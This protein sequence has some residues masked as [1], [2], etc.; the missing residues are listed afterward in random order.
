[1]NRIILA[2]IFTSVFAFCTEEVNYRGGA[3]HDGIFG[4]VREVPANFEYKKTYTYQLWTRDFLPMSSTPFVYGYRIF[5][6]YGKGILAFDMRDFHF[7]KFALE[8]KGPFVASPI[9]YKGI[10]F[11]G[12][13]KK[14]LFYALD[15]SGNSIK[16]LW[17]SELSGPVVSAA[18]GADDRVLV[19]TVYGELFCLNLKGEIMWKRR[20]LPKNVE[21]SPKLTYCTPVVRDGIIYLNNGRGIT[22][23][24]VADGSVNCNLR[25]QDLPEAEFYSTPCLSGKYLFFTQQTAVYRIDLE[26]KTVVKYETGF[27]GRGSPACDDRNVYVTM[28]QNHFCI[29][30]ETM[31]SLWIYER[32]YYKGRSTPLILKDSVV[33]TD[34][35]NCIYLI[36]KKT[37]KCLSEDPMRRFGEPVEQQGG[38]IYYDNKIFWGPWNDCSMRI[39]WKGIA[40]KGWH[41]W[42][43]SDPGIEFDDGKDWKTNILRDDPDFYED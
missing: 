23:W 43:D 40:Y 35:H 24:K 42:K 36:D 39:Y 37:G 5:F 28:G 22:G 26:Q 3:G 21:H 10:L 27:E 41:F 4:T 20:Y 6:G 34:A 18:C 32:G 9:V 29:D 14:N 31:E 19:T 15:I 2:I 33:F 1:M 38:P 13:R 30:Q 7:E 12:S 16:K 25:I 11:I 8:F 17:Q